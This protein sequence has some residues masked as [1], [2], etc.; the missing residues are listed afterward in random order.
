[1]GEEVHELR[2]CCK[3]LLEA[4]AK[5][6]TEAAKMVYYG[7]MH[8]GRL[9]ELH[10]VHEIWARLLKASRRAPSQMRDP[11]SRR[12]LQEAICAIDSKLLQAKQL[13][14]FF[15]RNKPEVGE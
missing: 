12:A 4:A 9:E 10:G 6:R 13:F 14:D 15:S 1:M 7:A 5:R 8:P 11:E 3:K 2:E